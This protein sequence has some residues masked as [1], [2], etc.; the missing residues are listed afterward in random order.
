ME[1]NYEPYPSY[2]NS[3]AKGISTG[4]LTFLSLGC[5]ML[6]LWGVSL[7]PGRDFDSWKHYRARAADV[8]PSSRH[9]S[10]PGRDELVIVTEGT[11]FY[12]WDR[13]CLLM[14]FKSRR[15]QNW[16]YKTMTRAKAE[17]LG[18]M[19]CFYCEEPFSTSPAADSSSKAHTGILEKK[20]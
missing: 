8:S 18:L 4:A 3:P 13:H 5:L 10:L 9:A 12:H 1:F 20:F 11:R 17:A 2:E 6:T 15:G 14:D 16:H 7:L 19:P